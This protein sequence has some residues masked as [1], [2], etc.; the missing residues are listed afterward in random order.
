MFVKQCPRCGKPL[1]AN[2][3][4]CDT[5]G[6]NLL[7][8]GKSG[9]EIPKSLNGIRLEELKSALAATSQKVKES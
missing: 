8:S 4:R 2:S 3:N 5:C 6:H 9:R 7:D 1:T